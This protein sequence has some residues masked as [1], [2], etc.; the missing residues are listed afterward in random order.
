VQRGLSE[1][2]LADWSVRIRPEVKPT[3]CVTWTYNVEAR[4]VVLALAMRPEVKQAI[5]AVAEQLLRDC[6]DRPHAEDLLR[7]ALAS[8]GASND[9]ELHT[10]GS[11]AGPIEREAEVHAHFE[12]GCW[13]YSGSGWLADGTPIY[14]IGGKS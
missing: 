11:E 12:A 4:E 1:A 2:G 13:I 14:V 9:Y 6:L 3:D 5:D 10:N 7:G 8:V